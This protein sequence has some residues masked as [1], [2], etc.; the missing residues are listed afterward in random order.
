MIYDNTTN[1]FA[2]Y[3]QL[4]YDINDANDVL[5]VCKLGFFIIYEENNVK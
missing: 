4:D 1:Q 2:T 3:I 5:L